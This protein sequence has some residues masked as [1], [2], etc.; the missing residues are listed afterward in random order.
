MGLPAYPWDERPDGLP[1]QIDE[2]CAALYRADGS[3]PRAADVLRIG[4]LLLRKY[5]A[6]SARAR[7]VIRECDD[8]L[9]DRAR[10]RLRDALESDQSVRQ[11]WATRYILSSSNARERGYAPTPVADAQSPQI[12][13]VMPPARWDDGTELKRLPASNPSS[14]PAEPPIKIID[15]E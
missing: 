6:R 13:L 3:I 15:H 8:L 14:P 7:A 11:D 9:I 12:T 2:V 4:T 5:V 10:E 1:L